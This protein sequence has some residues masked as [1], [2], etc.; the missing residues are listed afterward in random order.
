[1]CQIPLILWQ[2]EAYKNANCLSIDTA[3]PACTDD[4]IYGIMDILGIR[5]SLYDSSASIFN[6]NYKPKTRMV[7]GLLYED[8]VNKFN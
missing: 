6:H 7:Q 5:Y 2:N 1:M 4:V 3:R 8:I